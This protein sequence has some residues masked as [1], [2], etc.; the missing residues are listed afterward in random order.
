MPDLTTVRHF[1]NHVCVFLYGCTT[2]ASSP[3]HVMT[4]K[5]NRRWAKLL[6]GACRW[7]HTEAARI[8]CRWWRLL[9]RSLQ[10]AGPVQPSCKAFLSLS[11]GKSTDLQN[12]VPDVDQGVEHR[13]KW[14]Q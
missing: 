1:P 7:A 13:S 14:H 10:P 6:V 11:L 2:A 8:S 9:V 5:A 3:F 4:H 12:Q